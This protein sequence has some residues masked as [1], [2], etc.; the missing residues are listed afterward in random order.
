VSP[1]GRAAGIL[2]GVALTALVVPAQAVAL[3]GLAL[4]GAFVVDAGLARRPVRLQR[5]LPAIVS[6]GVAAPVEVV[7]TAPGRKP[8]RLRQA[9]TPDLE[10]TPREDRGELSA[11]LVGRRRGRH[12]LP[13]VTARVE[14]PLGLAFHD[15]RAGQDEEVLVYPDLALARRLALAVRHGRFRDPGRLA[16]GP[17][18]LGTEFESIRD[19]QPDDDIRQVN[20]AATERAGR[21]MSNAFR[22]EQDR[23]VLCLLDL[24]RL[25]AAPADAGLAGLERLD[26]TVDAAAA[27][28]LVADALGDRPGVIAFDTAV[29]RHVRC[30]HRGGDAVVRAIFDVE[31]VMTDSDYELAF[32]SVED[33]KRALVLVLTDLVDEAAARAL[34]EALPVLARRHHVVVAGVADADLR[35]LTT[36]PPAA[37]LDVYLAAAALDVLGARRRVVARL[38]AAGADVVEAP[39]DRLAAACVSAYLS[40]KRRARL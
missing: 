30:R 32:R 8:P 39:A 11:R 14:G 34:L 4:A 40:A 17:L 38:R 26:A 16:R 21:P 12:A 9:A 37:E 29:R 1:T 20:W 23:D 19:Y 2:A 3:A 10:V 35:A 25:M 36:M 24:G 7:V 18:G 22:L 5:R 6:R 27:V 13:V 15:H 28:A 33:S 31:P